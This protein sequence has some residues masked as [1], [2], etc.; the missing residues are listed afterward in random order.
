MPAYTRYAV[1]Y[2]PPKGSD[3]ASF[4]AAWL[5]WDNAAGQNVPHPNAGTVDVASITA[6]PRKYGFH[7]TMKPPFRLAEGTSADE[8]K[9]A[10]GVVAAKTAPFD[11]P[12]LTLKSLGYFL[13]LV[14]SAP[15][16][17]LA[18]LAGHCV[19]DLDQFRAQPTEAEL[20]KRRAAGLT[21]AQEANLQAW[22]YPYVL[23]QF[24]FHLTLSGRL[25]EPMLAKV[26]TVL[27]SLTAPF[28]AAPM[29]VRDIAILGEAGD[30]K[31][32]LIQRFKLTG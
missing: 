12:S 21:G 18:D 11:A 9:E 23:D 14:P 2:L 24:R 1:Y 28:C 13:A 7:G 25:A 10:V 3:L 31:F 22:G 20:I 27:E 30:G 19:M 4:G 32:H 17:P 29:P 15:C 16:P 26:G 8:L 5:G 6:T